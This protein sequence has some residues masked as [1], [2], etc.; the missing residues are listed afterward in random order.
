MVNQ[1][2]QTLMQLGSKNKHGF[3]KAQTAE[4]Q[5]IINKIEPIKNSYRERNFYER[6]HFHGKCKHNPIIDTDKKSKDEVLRE[7]NKE[8]SGF[9]EDC[10]QEIDFSYSSY[11]Y[12]LLTFSKTPKTLALETI[13]NIISRTYLELSECVVIPSVELLFQPTG[14]YGRTFHRDG[15]VDSQVH[16]AT[17]FLPLIGEGTWIVPGSKEYICVHPF[18][19]TCAERAPEYNA[20][21]FIIEG[22]YHT[23][24]SAPKTSQPR[25]VAH[26]DEIDITDYINQ[27][28]INNNQ[29][30]LSGDIQDCHNEICN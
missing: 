2:C 22:K 8:I 19:E 27:N 17:I 12:N 29:N 30:N 5:E 14:T 9:L 16:K 18:I 24:H 11:F 4:E 10:M 1:A 23:L 20:A 6:N 21:I 3:F 15:R 7:I 28:D 25:I 26:F 13:G